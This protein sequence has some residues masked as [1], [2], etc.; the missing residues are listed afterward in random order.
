MPQKRTN[1]PGRS[2]EELNDRERA[3]A[4]RVGELH[5]IDFVATQ[6]VSNVYR[7]ASAVRNHMERDVLSVDG[8]SWT[9]FTALFVLWVWG[10]QEARH[11]AEECGVSKGTL[12]GIVTTLEGKGL[13]SRASH[14]EDGRLVLISLTRT[15]RTVIERLFPR[16]N[17]HEAAVASA[18]T[19][20][21]QH[22]L[23][24]LLRKI[25]ATVEQ[26]DEPQPTP[27]QSDALNG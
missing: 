1:R 9:G 4:A 11:L 26:L 5:E 14:P 7:V 20:D 22:E 2:G 10:P 21:E 15:G 24:R 6:A 3:V 16:F 27:N 19:S 13:I 12:T 18:L 23:A 8:L 17:R 25:L